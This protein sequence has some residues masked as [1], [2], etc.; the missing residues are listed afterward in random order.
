MAWTPQAAAQ[1]DE[2]AWSVLNDKWGSEAAY[3]A[4]IFEQLVLTENPFHEARRFVAY[5]SE[6]DARG[7]IEREP[8]LLNSA[9]SH[10]KI[11]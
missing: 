1:D 4:S 8:K 10:R 2:T 6:E 7:L 3:S 9:I 5:Q 11:A